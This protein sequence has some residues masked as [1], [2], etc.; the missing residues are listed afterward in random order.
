MKAVLY[1]AYPVCEH[2]RLEKFLPSEWAIEP[3]PDSASPTEK[4]RQLADADVLVTS[5]YGCSDPP[6][7]RLRLLQCSSAGIENIDVERLPPG[8]SVCNVHGH[9]NGIAEY[10][11]WAILDWSINFRGIPPFSSGGTWSIDEWISIPNHSEA[12]GKTVGVVGYGHIGREVARR[13]RA[14]GLRVTVLSAWSK[15]RPRDGILEKAFNPNEAR[16]FL[17]SSDFVVVCCPL[18][19]DTRGMIDAGWFSA[20]RRG[21]VV[22]QVG[23]GPVIDEFAFFNALSK[24]YI[25]GATID[26]WYDYP[27]QTGERVRFS[28]YPFHELPNVVVTPHISARS[29]ES[30]DRRFSQIAE[31]LRALMDGRPLRNIVLRPKLPERN[32]EVESQ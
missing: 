24:K 17:E 2:A 28:R 32:L 27:R 12:S 14:L 23:R 4:K 8:C 10:V 7:P 29:E 19:R 20:M 18:T 9:E 1:G 11:I 21:T 5:K 6:A 13:A 26:V 22:I 3:V 25:R 15:G 31:N 16:P 30:W